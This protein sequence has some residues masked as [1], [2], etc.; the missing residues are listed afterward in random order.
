MKTMNRELNSFNMGDF[1]KW[2][3]DNDTH[4]E[5]KKPSPKGLVVESKVDKKS[6]LK[7]V[8]TVEGDAYEM[9]VDFLE[10]C[11]TV[12]DIDGKNFIIEVNSGT[13]SVPRNYVTR[14]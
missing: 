2:I 4:F 11:G 5:M 9:T 10:N 1:K 12:V 3:T 6:L 7:H 13:F 14:A 8:S